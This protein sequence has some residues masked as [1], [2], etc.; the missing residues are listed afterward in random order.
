[1]ATIV[2]STQEELSIA[3]EMETKH[4]SLV[5]KLAKACRSVEFVEKKG[6]NQNQNY[7][8]VRAT[9]VADAIRGEF[10]NRHIILVCDEKDYRHIRTIKTNSGGEMAEYLLHCEY[11]FV[12]GDTGEKL[13]PFGAFGTAMDSGDKHCYKAKTGALK[14][15]LR[16]IGLI[17]DEN[18]DPEK[19]ERVDDF[20]S[21]PTTSEPQGVDVGFSQV[22]PDYDTDALL[23]APPQP[24][25][26][27]GSCKACGGKVV[28]AGTS[29]KTG[30][31]YKAFC[32]SCKVP[33]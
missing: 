28:P 29:K 25:R 16:G 19:D 33:A 6:H 12:D 14:Y 10:F 11:T 26:A 2:A 9:D 4:E 27:A 3:S 23:D 15:V 7:N 20:T 31:P 5:T 32:S 13:G 1:M 8:Y 22:P 21:R 30:K 17:P 24:K 18:A